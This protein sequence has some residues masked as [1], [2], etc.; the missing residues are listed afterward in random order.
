MSAN[1]PLPFQER[2]Q[3]NQPQ[4]TSFLVAILFCKGNREG[5]LLLLRVA[6]GHRP[7]SHD[8]SPRISRAGELS[9]ERF[10]NPPPTPPPPPPAFKCRRR[11]APVGANRISRAAPG[12]AIDGVVLDTD[13]SASPPPPPPSFHTGTP[14]RHLEVPSGLSLL[15]FGRWR[16]RADIEAT[17]TRPLDGKQ[18]ATSNNI[19][20]PTTSSTVSRG[21]VRLI[22]K[23]NRQKKKQPKNEQRKLGNTAAGAECDKRR[24]AN[25]KMTSASLFGRSDVESKHTASAGVKSRRRPLIGRRGSVNISSST[26]QSKLNTHTPSPPPPPPTSHTST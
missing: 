3:P 8:N 5:T 22:P 11:S 26:A 20:H 21:I 19:Q 4:S 17:P 18:T 2:F 24:R 12:V 9:I 7:T 13:R 25:R 15:S 14:R 23:W 10:A 6:R 16:T 1:V